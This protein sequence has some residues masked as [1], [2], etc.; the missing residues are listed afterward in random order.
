[1]QWDAG[2]YAGFTTGAPWL[3]LSD[4]FGVRNVATL[5]NDPHS[6]LTL[7][8]NL[9]ALRR[10]HPAVA[11]GSYTAVTSVAEVLAYERRWDGERIFIALNFGRESCSVRLPTP[12]RSMLLSTHGDR[13]AEISSAP[14]IELRPNEGI[15]LDLSA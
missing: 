10:R 6:I 5:A 14:E 1:M 3:P 2:V 12:A 15:A 11:V 13:V 8:R 9:L 4:D 7:Y